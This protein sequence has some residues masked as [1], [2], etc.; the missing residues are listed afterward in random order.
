M[1]NCNAMQEIYAKTG[2]VNSSLSIKL[3][4]N[5]ENARYQWSLVFLVLLLKASHI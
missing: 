3:P 2:C 1:K 4:E 5:V